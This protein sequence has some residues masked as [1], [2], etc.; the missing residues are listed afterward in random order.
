MKGTQLTYLRGNFLE[1][2]FPQEYF[3]AGYAVQVLC[4]IG[5]K[6]FENLN[7]PYDEDADYRVLNKINELL[8]PE[9]F[10]IASLPIHEEYTVNGYISPTGVNLLPHKKGR[11]YDMERLEDIC[12]ETGFAL[13][14]IEIYEGWNPKLEDEQVKITDPEQN[15]MALCVFKK[16]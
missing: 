13:Q 10:F 6:Y 9:G 2:D 1:T 5:M 15:Y 16:L 8:K 11:I 12:E 14:E 4:H 7:E 3:E